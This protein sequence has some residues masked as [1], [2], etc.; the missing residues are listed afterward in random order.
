MQVILLFLHAHI[1]SIKTTI[2][3]TLD[4]NCHYISRKMSVSHDIIEHNSKL[5]IRVPFCCFLCTVCSISLMLAIR[6]L[7]CCCTVCSIVS[8]SLM[9][10]IRVLVCS[11][12]VSQWFQT[13]LYVFHINY[14]PLFAWIGRRVNSVHTS[15]LPVQ[16][17][18]TADIPSEAY[19]L[20][21]PKEHKLCSLE[22]K[23][24]D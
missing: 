16:Q 5:P 2:F 15:V 18:H 23:M 4:C 20:P 6:V 1:P 19:L 14:T 13:L 22:K 7:F 10:S 24:A 21:I 17:L 12:L 11:F 9:L 3:C 8:D